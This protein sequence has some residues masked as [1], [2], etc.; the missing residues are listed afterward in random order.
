KFIDECHKRKI[1]VFNDLVLNHAFESN[2]MAIMYWD[3]EPCVP[4][5]PNG[6]P[7]VD[8]PWF[9]KF[10]KMVRNTAGH[11]GVDWN[12][13][14]EHTQ[15]FMDRA[16]DFWLQEYQFD[17]FRFD[18]T[19]GFGQ[20]DP[21]DPTN[22][23]PL[24]DD[25][26]SS[27]KADRIGLLKRMSNGM[28]TRNPGS[29]VIFE[30]LA[31][32]NEDKELADY[33]IS[34]W[35]GVGHHNDVKGFIFGNNT[36]NTDIYN[37]GIYDAPAR[38]F[39]FANWMSYPESH[40]EQRLAYELW[41]SYGAFAPSDSPADSLAKV[42]DRLKIGWAY[43]L[44]FPGPR[45]I[46]QFGE[47]GYDF[48][49]NFNGR[50]GEKPVRWDYYDDLKR[51]ELYDFISK[52]LYIRNNYSIYAVPPDYGNI[53]LGAGNL[54][55][56]RR[57]ELQDGN[58]NYVLV[59]ANLDPSTN[60]SVQPSSVYVNGSTW[61]RYNGDPNIDGSLFTATSN[62]YDLSPSEVLVL[63]N[64]EIPTK[65]KLAVKINLEGNYD[66]ALMRSELNDLA[67]IPITEPF[68]AL[69]NF[70]HVG[71]GGGESILSAALD[72]TGNDA[73]VDWVFVEL[74]DALDNTQV[75]A[76]R[77]ALLQKDGDIVDM[78][79][80][81]PLAFQVLSG[82][83]YVVVKHRDHLGIMTAATV[84]LSNP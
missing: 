35:S 70:T 6:C 12:H 13:E 20:I 45:M 48:D 32:N 22:G 28:W 47:L 27:Y 7:S 81:S 14:S 18:F 66:G 60:R 2:V 67:Q 26:A 21:D 43:N 42:I 3:E 44:L 10:H 29:V 36:D 50:T 38:N 57:M 9:N 15:A 58:G 25:W 30:H 76:T 78:D 74:R 53:A 54:T 41:N 24:G 33:G 34:M 75:V 49:I 51:R 4:H 1:Q 82:D 79:G 69:P 11:W 37:S 39:L 77:S 61:Y 19:K 71:R 17:G 56:P 68:S 65:K 16:L 73:I 52:L 46:W 59:I 55:T 63:T 23:F 62:T 31:N 72:N 64:F 8:N 5:K 84:N 40:D 80:V 83:Y